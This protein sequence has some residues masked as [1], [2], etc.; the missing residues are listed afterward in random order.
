MRQNAFIITIL[1]TLCYSLT[2]SLAHA[3]ETLTIKESFNNLTGLWKSEGYGQ[4]YEITNEQ[5]L[6]YEISSQH[7]LLVE[8]HDLDDSDNVPQYVLS[9]VEKT[10]FAT[11]PALD[12]GAIHS[13]Y[14]NRVHNRPSACVY[15]IIEK[16]LSPISNFNVLW[17][18]FNE[19]YAYFDVRNADWQKQYDDNLWRVEQLT[20]SPEDQQTLFEIFGDMIS[21]LE[22]DAHTEVIY[23][24]PNNPDN[25]Q[26]VSPEGVTQMELRLI[27]EFHAIYSQDDILKIYS[28]Q[29]EFDSVEELTAYLFNEHF[30]GLFE[31]H[32]SNLIQY[33]DDSLFES[34]ANDKISWGTIRGNTGYLRIDGMAGFLE[35]QDM[36]ADPER[37]FSIVNETL[38]QVIA[39]LAETDSMIIDV[40]LNG[41]GADIISLMIA[42]RF[43]D[44]Q[45]DVFRKKT[46]HENGY[47]N[48]VKV[49]LPPANET[50]VKPIYL[51]TSELTGSAAEIFTLAMLNLP[52]VTQIGENTHGVFSDSLTKQLPNGS[53]FTLSNEIYLDSNGVS[54]EF[55]GLKPNVAALLFDK[56]FRDQ[57]QDSAIEAVFQLNGLGGKAIC[58]YQINENWGSGFTAEI[59]ITNISSG[60]INGWS[61]SW[62]FNDQS[63]VTHLWNASLSNKDPYQATHKPWN[64]V[65]QPGNSV[66]FGL[67]GSHHGDTAPVSIEGGICN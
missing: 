47:G 65:I 66:V 26:E 63:K 37:Q 51:L 59:R 27:S 33:F 1:I 25:I 55:V 54:H 32:D 56:I 14:Y 38:D 53:Y 18:T 43:F 4:L 24:D 22:S 15:G 45:R 12:I 11:D 44:Q 19:H 67:V 28:Q 64:K 58:E 42:S 21:V 10:R 6:I 50:Y 9:N 20:D 34:A 13:Y 57:Q 5:L 41:G 49:S 61:V 23:V 62:D 60:P 30:N 29:T 36:F 17:H 40:R 8:S 46:K 48:K 2:G 52:Y 7:C 39:D 3:N 35:N 16:T 31:E